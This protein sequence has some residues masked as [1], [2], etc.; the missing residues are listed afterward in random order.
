M[1]KISNKTL[2]K[3]LKQAVKRNKIWKK[4]GSKY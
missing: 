4:E 2:I 3:E 1:N